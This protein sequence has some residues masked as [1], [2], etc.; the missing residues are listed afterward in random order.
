MNTLWVILICRKF[1]SVFFSAWECVPKAGVLGKWCVKEWYESI[2]AN[3][4]PFST[5][6]HPFSL[7]LKPKVLIYCS[8]V[9]PRSLP[10]VSLSYSWNDH[11]CLFLLNPLFPSQYLKGVKRLA[12]YH[13]LSF[14]I[15]KGVQGVFSCPAHMP[16][17]LLPGKGELICFIW[18][19]C[20]LASISSSLIIFGSSEAYCITLRAG[21]DNFR[22]LFRFGVWLAP[23]PLPSSIFGW[24]STHRTICVFCFSLLNFFLILFNFPKLMNLFSFLCKADNFESDGAL[25]NT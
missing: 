21:A 17:F 24:F 12:H 5:V 10:L 13:S 20:R 8:P 3:V 1:Y 23:P 19:F 22:F 16:L 11:S 9:F 15:T 14:P 25:A 6:F 18:L 4:P 7:W 2:K